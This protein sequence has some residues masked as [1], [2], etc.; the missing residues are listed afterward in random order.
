MDKPQTTDNIIVNDFDRLKDR[1]RDQLSGHRLDL[2]LAAIY[3]VQKDLEIEMVL[4]AGRK[5]QCLNQ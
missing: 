3:S 2:C 4:V 5:E 1:I